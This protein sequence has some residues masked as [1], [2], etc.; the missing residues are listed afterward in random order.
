MLAR[1]QHPYLVPLPTKILPQRRL[2]NSTALVDLI[3]HIPL[4]KTLI[5][6]K[7]SLLGSSSTLLPV[8]ARSPHLVRE[9][10]LHTLAC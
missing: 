8:Q 6:K 7:V 10:L 5:R 9:L 3:L 1:L 2:L 4:I